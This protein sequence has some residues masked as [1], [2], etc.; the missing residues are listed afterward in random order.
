MKEDMLGLPQ[1][2]FR[3]NL[4]KSS[5]KILGKEFLQHA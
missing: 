3:I 1:G 4:S 2:Q 5:G